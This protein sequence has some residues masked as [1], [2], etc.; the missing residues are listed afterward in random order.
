MKQLAEGVFQLK[1]R[2]P[3]PNAINTYLV[4]DVLVDAD[5]RTDA[6]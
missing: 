4:G 6:A 5:G 3:I 1:G 2:L